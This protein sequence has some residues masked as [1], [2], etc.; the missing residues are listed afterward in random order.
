MIFEEQVLL[1]CYQNNKSS[2]IEPV[3]YL[4][5]T[6]DYDCDDL[7]SIYLEAKDNDEVDKM[8]KDKFKKTVSSV[9]GALKELKN[10][11]IDI[12]GN[13][14]KRLMNKISLGI[15]V[16]FDIILL[17]FNN[18][19]G[20]QAGYLAGKAAYTTLK[21]DV[22]TALEISSW[23]SIISSYAILIVAA[24]TGVKAVRKFARNDIDILRDMRD[25]TKTL[26]SKIKDEESVKKLK[27]C[28][29]FLDEKIAF[30]IKLA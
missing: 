18:L 29:E 10:N 7:L 25:K 8:M 5:E 12:T 17:H 22:F 27:D 1:N 3:K 14:R 15:K 16:L 4:I 28:E 19:I 2:F 30:A 26:I 20:S 24:Y 9:K 13:K 11:K 21:I 6:A 23:V